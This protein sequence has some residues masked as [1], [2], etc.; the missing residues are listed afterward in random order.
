V[1]AHFEADLEVGVTL[2][3]GIMASSP[4]GR[5]DQGALLNLSIWTLAA[6][7]TGFLALRVWAKLRRDRKLWWDDHFLTAAWVS[8]PSTHPRKNPQDAMP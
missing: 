2:G 4:S 1:F 6:G 3:F 7:S 8:A 5:I